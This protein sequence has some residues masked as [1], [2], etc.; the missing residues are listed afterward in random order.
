MKI[1]FYTALCNLFLVLM[2]SQT[3]VAQIAFV[4]E[5]GLTAT[6]PCL[7]PYPMT[8]VGVTPPQPGATTINYTASPISGTI[9]F[10]APYILFVPPSS[11]ANG[12]NGPF[13]IQEGPIRPPS[14]VITHVLTMPPN[15]RAFYFHATH[16]F[17]G[18]AT[19]VVSSPGGT[20]SVGPT[21]IPAAGGGSTVTPYFGFYTTDPS[22]TITQISITGTLFLGLLNFGIY[23]GEFISPTQQALAGAI[24]ADFTSVCPNQPVS[25]KADGTGNSFVFTGPNGYVFSSV[26]RSIGTHSAFATDITQPG[27]YTLTTALGCTK[28]TSTITLS[29]CP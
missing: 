29:A 16:I 15:T 5:S 1:L 28:S 12:Y 11:F 4:P 8:P 13:Y 19:V 14:T 10:N 25:L 23:Q 3:T 2:L 26:Y 7:G 6:K 22:S 9:G 24:S 20:T 18:D 21:T 27:L 17:G